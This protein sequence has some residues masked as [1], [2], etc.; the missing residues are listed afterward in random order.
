M[1][2]TTAPDIRAEHERHMARHQVLTDRRAALERQHGE[3]TAQRAERLASGSKV[4]DI[5]TLSAQIRAV[6]DERDMTV[7]ALAH[8]AQRIDETRA[9][10]EAAD[11]QAEFEASRTDLAAAVERARA[12]RQARSDAIRTFLTETFVAVATAAHEA[13]VAGRE[14]QKRYNRARS[15]VQEGRPFDETMGE[16][17]WP[18]LKYVDPTD[19][20]ICGGLADLALALQVAPP[21]PA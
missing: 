3:L 18:L 10:V 12:T 14:A 2:P 19:A 20:R 15:L 9:A 13:D 11:R 5:D 1:P 7:E 21:R 16:S 6:A 8:L 17:G 4:A